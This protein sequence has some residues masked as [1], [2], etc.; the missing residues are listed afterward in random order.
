MSKQP[1]ASKKGKK[2]TP[3]EIKAQ[4]IAAQKQAEQQKESQQKAAQQQQLKKQALEIYKALNAVMKLYTSQYIKM[5]SAIKSLLDKTKNVTDYKYISQKTGKLKDL[6]AKR[7]K[8]ITSQTY[9]TQDTEKLQGQFKKIGEVLK[10]ENPN[11]QAIIDLMQQINAVVSNLANQVARLSISIANVVASIAASHKEFLKAAKAK[12]PKQSSKQDPKKA[13]KQKYDQMLDFALRLSTE[14]ATLAKN[15][16]ATDQ[17]RINALDVSQKA[18]DQA[19]EFAKAN[20]I[21]TV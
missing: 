13:A 1:T 21:K 12:A 8:I 10:T 3:E 11:Y 20:G 4:Q 5:L 18:F 14:A 16:S 6:S 17:A 7:N 15:K 2:A 9:I 19:Q